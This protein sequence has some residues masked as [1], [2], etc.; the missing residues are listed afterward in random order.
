MAL[1]AGTELEDWPALDTLA[2]VYGPIFNPEQ[3]RLCLFSLQERGTLDDYIREFPRLSL[4]VPDLDEHSRAVLFVNG[5]SSKLRGQVLKEHP[6]TLDEAI[7]ASKMA[8]SC[9]QMSERPEQP[10]HDISMDFIMDLPLT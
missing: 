3:I 2:R 9:R 4:Q 5:L 6:S 7:K 1:E 10:W 8:E